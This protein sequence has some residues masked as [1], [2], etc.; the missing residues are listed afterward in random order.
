[1]TGG[2]APVMKNLGIFGSVS[3]KNKDIVKTKRTRTPTP[4]ETMKFTQ[5]HILS[6]L[7][8]IIFNKG[9]HTIIISIAISKNNEH[10]A[11]KILTNL[12]YLFFT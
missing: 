1:M 4:P 3:H 8:P 9:I 6:T 10:L 5:F 11:E 12:P 7:L 2:R